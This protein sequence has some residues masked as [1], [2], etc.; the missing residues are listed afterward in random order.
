MK[1]PN[2]IVSTS[3]IVIIYFDDVYGPQVIMIY[4]K[5]DETKCEVIIKTIKPMMDLHTEHDEWNFLYADPLFISQNMK[6]SH[7]NS[8]HRGGLRDY[9]ISIVVTPSEENFIVKSARIR[10]YLPTIQEL[11]APFLFLYEREDCMEILSSLQ[12][13]MDEV[14]NEL[15][16]QF[17]HNL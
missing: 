11:C 12:Q 15:N 13:E 4:P 9:V 16:Y 7:I 5:I 14:V 6:F 10:N 3:H 8:K 1:D 17:N 2:K